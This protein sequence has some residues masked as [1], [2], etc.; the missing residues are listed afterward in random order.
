MTEDERQKALLD[1][2]T[3]EAERLGLYPKK[4]EKL[5][6]ALDEGDASGL[7]EGDATDSVLEE[8][9]LDSGTERTE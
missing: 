5:R 4:M 9:G 3:Q 1:E 2:L 6:R 7:F 8:L